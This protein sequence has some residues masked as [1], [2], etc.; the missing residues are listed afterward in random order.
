MKVIKSTKIIYCD[1]D[2]TLV[3]WDWK[4]YDPDGKDLIEIKDIQSGYS[5]FLLPHFRHVEFLKQ[6]KTRGHT[7]VVWS[8]GGAI[9]CETVVKALGLEDIVDICISKPD[10]YID[11]MHA[12]AYFGNNI[13]KHPTDP[14]KDKS[15][16]N[17]DDE[18]KK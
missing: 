8:Q 13:Y 5:E 7:I 4:Q 9:W 17:L 3:L 16:W 11:D 14:S 1:V 2:E 15:S 6:F 12:S 18:D 10:W